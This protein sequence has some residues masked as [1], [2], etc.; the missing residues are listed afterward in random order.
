GPTSSCRAPGARPHAACSWPASSPPTRTRPRSPSPEAS[1]ETLLR[2]V[3]LD[4]T[5][6]PPTAEEMALFLADRSPE[7]WEKAV[8]SRRYLMI[9]PFV[10][11]WLLLPCKSC[12]GSPGSTGAG[13]GGLIAVR[14]ERISDKV[15]IPVPA[16]SSGE[17]LTIQGPA[18]SDTVSSVVS[19]LAFDDESGPAASFWVTSSFSKVRAKPALPVSI[20][21]LR[22]RIEAA[23]IN[24][25]NDKRARETGK[26][27]IDTS[28]RHL[29]TTEPVL[30]VCSRAEM[31]RA[32]VSAEVW[33]HNPR[34]PPSHLNLTIWPEGLTIWPEGVD[35]TIINLQQRFT[36]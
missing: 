8:L 4:L 31:P 16:S 36:S 30:L 23:V 5:G 2:R 11:R 29:R 28:F 35:L 1:R 34:V 25:L 6:L 7:A 33:H 26:N 21:R 18:R 10:K 9:I 27:F 12:P 32:V 20:S 13:G 3:S 19:V 14:A 15:S 24:P 22:K 17:V